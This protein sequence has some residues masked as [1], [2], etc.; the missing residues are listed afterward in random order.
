MPSQRQASAPV[1]AAD[2]LAG[3]LSQAKEHSCGYRSQD[4]P[5]SAAQFAGTRTCGASA[6]VT[7][8]RMARGFMYLV[9]VLD[10]HSRY[11]LAWQLSN[12][13]DGRFC[14][15]ALRQALQQGRPEIFTTDQG[16]QFT[17]VAFTSI[18]EAAGVRI[19]M[20]GRGCALD[21]I[22]VERLWRSTRLSSQIATVV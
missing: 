1:N 4:L 5:V 10:W 9:A 14:Q 11:V 21:N 2:G 12:T 7:Y 18:L 19:S 16:V 20:D 22:F 15:P 13:L 17:A 8:I 3:H 6:G